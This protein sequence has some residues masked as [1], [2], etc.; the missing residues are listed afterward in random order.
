MRRGK[1]KLLKKIKIKPQY[2]PSSNIINKPSFITPSNINPQNKHNQTQKIG[3][4]N[5]NA[6]I[7]FD[8]FTPRYSLHPKKNEKKNIQINDEE[9]KKVTKNFL[10]SKVLSET[11]NTSYS[12]CGNQDPEILKKIKNV[13]CPICQELIINPI[14]CQ[15]CQYLFCK[16]CIEEF[17]SNTE[18]D[19][20]F[21]NHNFI[22][23]DNN[24]D[25]IETFNEILLNCP[26]KENGCL[27]KIKMKNYDEHIQNCEYGMFNIKGSKFLCENCKKIIGNSGEIIIHIKKCNPK[28]SNSIFQIKEYPNNSIYI[29]QYKNDL[30]DG[31]GIYIIKGKRFFEGM[32]KNDIREGECRM[33]NIDTELFFG[34]Q[35]NTIDNNDNNIDNNKNNTLSKSTLLNNNNENL[36]GKGILFFPPMGIVF[37]GNFINGKLNGEGEVNIS[38]NNYYAKGNFINNKLNG[39]GMHST[40]EEAYF[41]YFKNGDKNGFGVSILKNGFV[42]S[43]MWENGKEIGYFGLKKFGQKDYLYYGE[44]LGNG[45]KFFYDCKLNYI[46]EK[47]DLLENDGIGIFVGKKTGNIYKGEFKNNLRDG[48]G[49][50]YNKNGKIIEQG[51]YC[52]GSLEFSS[53]DSNQVIYEENIE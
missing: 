42:R 9:I 13:M 32:W 22:K 35:Y 51:F 19:K 10:F 18:K 44:E 7:K 39:F 52:N 3:I 24:D 31:Y 53:L 46:G 14:Q 47:N 30:R 26:Y 6:P 29:G 48:Y 21:F 36:N 16:K 15:A 28:L 50:V 4:K 23:K 5:K 12:F 45:K 27:E 43:G 38:H 49:T 41:G 11:K 34:F 37:K 20:C 33:V 1:P 40:D 17:Q 2:S 8:N 25:I